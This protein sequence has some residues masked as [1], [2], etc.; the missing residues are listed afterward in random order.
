MSAGESGP[1]HAFLAGRGR[2]G[3]GRLLAEVLAFDDQRL[4]AV[5]DFV[6]WLFPLPEASRAVPGAPVLDPAQ[7]AAIRADPVALAGLR[8]A[9]D[10]MAR[11]YAGTDHWL[12]AHD[13]NHLRITRI[14]ASLRD[15]V[16]PD[17][18]RAFHDAVAA[19][20][21]AAGG[22][23]NRDSLGFWERACG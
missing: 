22:P 19:R 13:H 15:L 20:N 23:V 11:F 18:A 6:Q 9:R 8:A 7:A 5:H 16:G 1:I 4:E 3:R 2:D 12:V 10:R 17:E 21:R 14:L